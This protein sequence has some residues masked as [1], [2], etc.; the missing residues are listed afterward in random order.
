MDLHRAGISSG[1]SPPRRR[2]TSPW[3]RRQI[4]V[5]WSPA[6]AMSSSA[7]CTV[8]RWMKCA[9]GLIGGR[10]RWTIILEHSGRSTSPSEAVQLLDGGEQ[11]YPRMLSAIDAAHS[12]VHLEVY[13]FTPA[14]VGALFVA[15]LGQAAGRGVRVHVVIDGWG[16]ARAETPWRPR[17]ARQAARCGS[18]TVCWRCS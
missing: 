9:T 11:A 15:A 10:S 13:A 18:T 6:D 8:G 12:T 1:R 2:A 14:G 16:S 7:A 3:R 4:M 17:C 5:L